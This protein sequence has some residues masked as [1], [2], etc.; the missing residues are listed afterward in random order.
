MS[1]P[2]GD[3]LSPLITTQFTIMHNEKRDNTVYYSLEFYIRVNRT[4][5]LYNMNTCF[6]QV[7]MLKVIGVEMVHLTMLNVHK[8]YTLF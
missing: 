1:Y 2:Q 5:M 7:Y 6:K 3:L 8:F 4:Y